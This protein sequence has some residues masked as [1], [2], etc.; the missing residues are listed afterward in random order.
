[1]RNSRNPAHPVEKPKC[2]VDYNKYMGGVDRTDQLLERFK[3]ARKC[4]KWY[5]KLALQLIQLSLLNSF[6]LYKKDGARKLL[7]DFQRSVIASLLFTKN[8]LEIPREEAIARLTE[9]HFIA[10]IPP[11]E[12]KDTRQKRCR[13]CTQK[14]TR[15]E[16]RYHCPTCP[17][18]PGLCY[19][20]CFE[21]YHTQ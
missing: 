17:S 12:K 21:I 6:L 19:H 11:T 10:L 14:N 18:N 7:L 9:R 8:T 13:I 16:S 15:K 3:V 2:I 20:P 5:K 1:M 4:M